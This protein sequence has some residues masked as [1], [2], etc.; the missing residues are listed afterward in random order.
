MAS[1]PDYT[2]VTLNVYVD[3][4]AGLVYFKANLDGPEVLIGAAKTGRLEK[5]Q[6]LYDEKQQSAPSEPSPPP[7]A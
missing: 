2:G 5:A 6:R 4:D 7:A 3:E 1:T